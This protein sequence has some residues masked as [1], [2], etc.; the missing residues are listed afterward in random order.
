MVVNRENSIVLQV[1][2]HHA[3]DIHNICIYHKQDVYAKLSLASAPEVSVST[4]IVNGGGK[5][6]VFNETL[7]LNVQNSDSS[8]KCEVWMLSRAKNFLED[9]L[10][11][12]VLVPLSM[13]AGKG[14]VTQEF[15]LSST[16]LFHSPAGFIQLS[17]CFNGVLSDASVISSG[18]ASNPLTS[19]SDANLL[20][21]EVD[22]SVPS[23]YSKIEFPDPQVVNENDRMVTEY[24]EI[25]CNLEP[26]KPESLVTT[27]VESP[28]IS[29]SRDSSVEESF[30]SSVYSSSRKD[31][32]KESPPISSNS[33]SSNDISGVLGSQSCE[34]LSSQTNEEK[35]KDATNL[36][37]NFSG[38]VPKKPIDLPVFAINLEPEQPVVQQDIVEMYMRSV[39]Q[40]T[41]SLEKMKLPMDIKNGGS[42]SDGTDLS[43]IK[44]L[45]ASKT[46]GSRVFYGSRAFF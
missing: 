3:R 4:Q 2:I 19:G 29:S 30:S 46:T 9:Q 22:A 10:L 14:R 21:L 25:A 12:F 31:A 28:L 34:H 37:T 26:Q 17:L 39:Q 13:V 20:D 33:Q 35:S 36:E 18:Q 41:E 7:Q 5:N 40:S 6:P 1:Y 43:S 11:G 45:Q 16:D 38:E 24:F 32:A 15:S 27:T 8:L 42:S 23:E 44:K